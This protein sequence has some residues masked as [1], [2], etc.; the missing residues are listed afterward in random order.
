MENLHQLLAGFHN[1]RREMLAEDARFFASLAKSQNPHT[2]VI[3][4]CDSRVDPGIILGCRPGDLFVVRNVAAIVPH[5]APVGQPDA[6]MAAVEYGVKHLEVRHVVV[7]GHSNCGGIHG[8]L[9]PEAVAHEDYIADWV[10]QAAP[11]AASLEHAESEHERHRLA[12]EGAV[13]L[14]I[15]NL[16]SYDW[17]RERTE[18]G[19]L[20]LHAVY[21]DLENHSL[22]LWDAEKEDFVPTPALHP[23]EK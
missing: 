1:F 13:L 21:Y 2:L 3:A 11:A 12:E 16:L 23:V 4:C 9:H 8:L 22:D 6:V 7:M 5:A 18:A 20:A 15:D 14:S 19:L 17:I 10:K